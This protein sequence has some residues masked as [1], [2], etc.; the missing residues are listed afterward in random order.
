MSSLG[1]QAVALLR[2]LALDHALYRH[3]AHWARKK[4]ARKKKEK[5]A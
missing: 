2:L 5:A 4:R 1:N 3:R